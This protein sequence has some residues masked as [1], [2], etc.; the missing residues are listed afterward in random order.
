MLDFE[1]ILRRAV[2]ETGP[3]PLAVATP[4]DIPERV[5]RDLA[6]EGLLHGYIADAAPDRKLRDPLLAGWWVD[7]RAGSWFIQ[8]SAPDTLVLLGAG[9]GHLVGGRMLLEARLKGVRRI[10][11]I[12]D[13]G[14]ILRDVDT[15]TALIETLDR[16][17]DDQRIGATGY[18]AAFEELYAA[19]GDR[20]RLTA[21]KFASDR[22]VLMIGSLGPGG[23]ERQAA[24]TAIG[25]QQR[26][27][28]EVDLGCNHIEA[29]NDFFRPLVEAAGATVAM[30]PAQSPE[31]DLPEV[32]EIRNRLSRYDALGFQNI[33]HS[34]FHYAHLLRSIRPA[35]VHTWTDYCNVLAGTAAELVGVPTL[36]LSGR[37]VA[38]DSF[39][40]F[41]PYMRP[42]YEALLRRR[43]ALF[44]NNSHAGAAD[45]ARWLALPGDRF[46]VIHNGFVFPAQA[47]EAA[48]K[49][50]RLAHGLPEDA[51]VVGSI[52]RFSDEKRPPLLIDMARRL[53]EQDSSLRFLFFGGGVMLESMRAYVAG[54]GL[55]DIVKLPGLTRDVWSA[56]SAM[57]IF[58]LTSRMEG[59]PN[60]LIEA[61]ALGLPV[62]CT[63]VGGMPETFLEGETGFSV[64]SAT[65]EALAGAVRRILTTPD[66][67][68]RMSG[69]AFAHA[70][71]AFGVDKMVE[72]TLNAYKD[73]APAA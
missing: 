15:E 70:R 56:L 31:Y 69:R 43:P 60:V 63:G 71:E 34:I 47:P 17:S 3:A 40:I 53:H 9:P 12:G 4:F 6:A 20:L 67:L 59:L 1:A 5:L 18:E 42:G 39:R 73:A 32:I 25:I 44:L 55:Q 46:R 57:D 64:P 48:R 36:V 10:V 45:Y 58:A 68:R 38:P 41:Q 54:C 23:A 28:Y 37:S 29:P 13:T 11:L 49:N 51:V 52:L 21:D 7:R 35:I 19:A 16:I 24:Y 50:V 65:P 8:R 66:L 14:A 2:R 27:A 72:L 30:V 22:V 26:N 61:Q 62:V 33:F